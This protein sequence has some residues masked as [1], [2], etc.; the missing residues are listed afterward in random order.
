[1]APA[2]IAE[3]VESLGGLRIHDSSDY[4]FD[5]SVC[6]ARKESAPT[7]PLNFYGMSKL[8]GEVAISASKCKHLI[9]LTSWVYGLSGNN[10]VKTI[11][12]RAKKVKV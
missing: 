12:E 10:F 3:E 11:L 6:T 1:M 9:L 5:G 2:R 8:A 4:V 7:G